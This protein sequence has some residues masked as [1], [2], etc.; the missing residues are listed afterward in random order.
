MKNLRTLLLISCLV[1]LGAYLTPEAKAGEWDRKTV[2][3]FS[4]PV[5][6]PG[7]V[8]PAG[9]Y[10]FNFLGSTANRNLIEVLSQDEQTVYATIE[11]IPD[12]RADA[13][14]ETSI[15]FEER[16]AGAP[17][18]IKEWFFP[19]RRYGHEFVYPEMGALELVK[20][21]EPESANN[22]VESAGL[23]STGPS[24][25]KNEPD[26]AMEHSG[27][28]MHPEETDY[29]RLLHQRQTRVVE[30]TKADESADK[31]IESAGLSYLQVLH[32]RQIEA[33]EQGQIPAQTAMLSEL[34][35]TG[36][37]LPLV[38]LAGMLLL[39]SSVGLRL[40]FKRV[41]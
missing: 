37:P 17:Q 26:V 9:T 14:G 35:R 24:S 22:P 36:S 19:D 20:S 13:S 16:I 27:Q 41:D 39:A 21:D 8:L 6:I 38:G 28:M 5:E 40:Y 32:Q 31:P 23:Q 30:L 3:T 4:Q 7:I 10:V 34:P 12:Y 18:A 2:L 11:A 15:V 29:L 1:Y 33:L 25:T